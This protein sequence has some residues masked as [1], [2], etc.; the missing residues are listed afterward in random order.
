M[1]K[2]K[3]EYAFVV[4]TLCNLYNATK[5]FYIHMRTCKYYSGIIFPSLYHANIFFSIP[6]EHSHKVVR[7]L[8]K[9]HALRLSMSVNKRNI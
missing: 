7:Q 3:A 2:N 6:D 1:R 8:A 9:S 4:D 5:L